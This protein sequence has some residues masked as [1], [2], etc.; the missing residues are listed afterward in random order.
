MG[1]PSD[2]QNG[3]STMDVVKIPDLFNKVFKVLHLEKSSEEIENFFQSLK[4]ILAQD[5]K[6]AKLNEEKDL[7]QFKNELKKV[8][9]E[10]ELEEFT[11]EID[12]FYG[13]LEEEQVHLDAM[14]GEPDMFKVLEWRLALPFKTVK[15][16]FELFKNGSKLKGYTVKVSVRMKSEW[17]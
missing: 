17:H 14:E 11:E 12:K 16:L 4:E 9:Y 5:A 15:R 10:S 3:G 6:D 13:E 8:L 2:E 1:F 7:D